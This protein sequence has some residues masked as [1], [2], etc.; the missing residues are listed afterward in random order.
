M[1]H[2]GNI[3]MT[4]LSDFFKF[5]DFLKKNFQQHC[6]GFFNVLA[7]HIIHQRGNLDSYLPT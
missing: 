5:N 4:F 1:S 7:I 6:N 3:P 2:M